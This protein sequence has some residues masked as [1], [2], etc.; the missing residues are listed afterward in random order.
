MLTLPYVSLMKMKVFRYLLSLPP[1][2][3]VFSS[4]V[5]LPPFAAPLFLFSPPGVSPLFPFFLPYG[6]N[7]DEQ[8]TFMHF[9]LWL[10]S[11]AGMN[12]TTNY[13][14]SF[15]FLLYFMVSPR[16]VILNLFFWWLLF[17]SEY[18]IKAGQLV[19]ASASIKTYKLAIKVSSWSQP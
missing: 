18:N 5:P 7:S 9:V 10:L 14:T 8:N 15:S 17:F 13:V 6:S 2:P 16:S 3:F 4:S 11:I 12:N 19:E 1:P